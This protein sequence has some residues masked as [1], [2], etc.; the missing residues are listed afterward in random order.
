MAA[1]KF[2]KD[3]YINLRLALGR[4][5]KLRS[6]FTSPTVAFQASD[7][8]DANQERLLFL[9][10]YGRSGTQLLSGLLGKIDRVTSFH[11]PDFWEDIANFTDFKLDSKL[12]IEYLAKYRSIQIYKRW[13]S[14]GEDAFYCESTGTIRYLAPV[15]AECYPKANL[16]LVSRD[17]RGVVRSMMGWGQFY[18]ESSKGAYAL[19]PEMGDPFFDQWPGMSRFERLCWSWQDTYNILMEAIPEVRWLRLEQLTTDYD[20]FSENLTGPVGLDLSYE[21]WHKV[22]SVKSINASQ[23]YEF[24]T[25]GEWSLEEQQAFIRICG[26]TMSRLGYSI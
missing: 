10:G 14:K 4:G 3:I 5:W 13:I 21:Q 25:W 19:E 20:Y 24:P 16:F 1:R 11:E 2:H 17:G 6:F 9:L 23:T 22:V 18:G 15:I 7:Y 12:A 8:V 26:D